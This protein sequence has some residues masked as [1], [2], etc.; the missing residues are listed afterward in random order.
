MSATFL[1][2]S[3]ICE[4]TGRKMKSKQI[5]TLRSNGLPFIVNATGHPVVARAAIEGRMAPAAIAPKIKPIP[6]LFRKN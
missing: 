4:L 1:D 2:S 5:A 3:E 6:R